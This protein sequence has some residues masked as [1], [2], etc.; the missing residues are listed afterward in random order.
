VIHILEFFYVD[1]G[2]NDYNQLAELLI[3][4]F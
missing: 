4:K 3:K 1:K 2:L